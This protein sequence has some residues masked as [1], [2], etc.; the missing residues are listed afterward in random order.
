M[1]DEQVG[2]STI[3]IPGWLWTNIFEVLDKHSF[4]DPHVHAVL[5]EVKRYFDPDAV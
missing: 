3:L 2:G 5:E 4:H 1:P